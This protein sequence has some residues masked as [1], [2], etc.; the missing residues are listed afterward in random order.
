MSYFAGWGIAII[1][2]FIC[3]CVAGILGI[4]GMILSI[5][6]LTK[7]GKKPLAIIGLVL[8]LFAI[9]TAAYFIIRILAGGYLIASSYSGMNNLARYYYNNYY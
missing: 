6:G 1:A 3:C 7:P 2:I 8:S 5:V 4:I 9:G